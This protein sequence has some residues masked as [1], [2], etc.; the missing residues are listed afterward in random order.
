MQNLEVKEAKAAIQAILF[1]SGE[2]ISAE[3]ISITLDLDKSTVS[4]L[5]K[6]L[7]DD[8]DREDS[9]ICIIKLND[10]YQ[11][12]TK[13]IC[14]NYVRRALDLRRHVPLSQAAMEVL[15]II[16]YNQPVTKSF[17][18]N[19]RGVDCSNIISNLNI[20]NLIEEKGRLDLPGRPLLYGTTLN[21]LKCF[22]IAS[23]DELPALK[24]DKKV[25]KGDF[26]EEK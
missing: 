17:V 13:S 24:S 25:V 16:A 2:P 18:E 26:L 10:K 19:I 20:R 12:C 23:V 8:F 3:R 15:A 6:N 21:F 14:S 1:A 5:L 9:G 22:G 11:M 4:K 7:M